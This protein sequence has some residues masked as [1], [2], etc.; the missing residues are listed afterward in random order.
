MKPVS[1]RKERKR[2]EG[3]AAGSPW[4]QSLSEVPRDILVSEILSPVS[5]QEDPHLPQAT[6]SWVSVSCM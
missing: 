5:F 2:E 3:L 1:L 6:S 4:F